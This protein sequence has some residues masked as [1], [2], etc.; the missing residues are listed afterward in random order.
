MVA[1]KVRLWH[2]FQLC[3][4][5]SLLQDPD[6][7]LQQGAVHP[8]ASSIQCLVWFGKTDSASNEDIGHLIVH[9]DIAYALTGHK[10]FACQSSLTNISADDNGLLAAMLKEWYADT[11]LGVI[12]RIKR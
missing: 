8:P 12:K 9:I 2:G 4:C 6:R 10:E 7:L 1:H 11:S 3:I 5:G